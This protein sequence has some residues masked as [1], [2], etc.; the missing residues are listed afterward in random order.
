[1]LL[2]FPFTDLQTA[3]VRPGLVVSSDSFNKISTDAIFIFIT[4]KK[5]DTAFDLRINQSDPG[6]QYTGLRVSSTLRISKLMCLEQKLAI[7]RLG[8]ADKSILQKVDSA[9]MRLFGL[10]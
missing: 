9:L 3:K 6:F 5:Y 2:S 1:L 4:S 7:R 10:R 8:H